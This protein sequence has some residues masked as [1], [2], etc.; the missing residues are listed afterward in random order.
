M[1]RAAIEASKRDAEE[2]ARPQFDAFDG[3]NPSKLEK[4]LPTPEDDEL[5]HAVSLSMKTAEQERLLRE[6]G[7]QDGDQSSKSS[8]KKVEDVERVTT[9]NRRQGFVTSNVGTSGKSVM[10]G[11]DPSDEEEA[12]DVEEEP[13]IRHRSGHIASGVV[14]AQVVNSPASSSQQQEN[15]KQ[16]PNG[17]V[18]PSNEWG[19]M[20]SEEH[21]EAVMLE[22]A[23]FGGIPDRSS[24][25]FAYPPDAL[26]SG[27]DR[28]SNFYPW[29][30]RP[31]SPTLT[32]QRLLREQQDDEYLAALQADREKEL[33]ATQEA[34]A[35]RQAALERE[36]HKEEEAHRKLIEEEEFERKLS[37]KQA[38]LPQEPSS[39]NE[40]SVT[41]LI[42]MPDGSRCGRRFL[43][44][45]RLQ[46]LFDYIDVGRLVKPGTYR[47]VRPYPRQTFTDGEGAST[48]AELGLTG[49]QEALF[50]ELI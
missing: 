8:G 33:K 22:A 44:S 10:E 27:L 40:N 20:S 35:A 26:Q 29:V 32:A 45:D 46:I 36:K 5:A 13:L 2:S 23:I 6:L 50:L 17:D 7:V 28:N 41:L 3:S 19:G 49:K 4:K 18:F 16:Q 37:A 48:L 47:L 43:K 42:R 31:G 30:P 25:N 15:G 34:A 24:Y 39:D 9:S 14:D 1:I 21:D 11:D 38:T 12:E